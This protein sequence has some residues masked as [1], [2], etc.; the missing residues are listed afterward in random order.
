MKFVKVAIAC[1]FLFTARAE[2]S[3]ECSEEKRNLRFA[4]PKCKADTDCPQIR[5]VRA[6]CP[7]I[8]CHKG[9]CLPET[10]ECGANKCKPGT[11]CCNESCGICAKPGEACQ[12]NLCLP[13]GGLE[14]EPILDPRSEEQECK[15]NNGCPQVSTHMFVIMFDGV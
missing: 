2:R 8:V 14:D 1:V 13:P 10:V 3:V 12:K 15:D 6:P 5:C 4:N 7:Q 11:V 9:S